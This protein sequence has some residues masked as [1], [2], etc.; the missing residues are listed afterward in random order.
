M[1]NHVFPIND[2]IEHNTEGFECS[3]NPVIDFENEIVIH[4]SLDR[5]ECFEEK[6]SPSMASNSSAPENTSE[7]RLTDS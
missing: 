3:C 4:N 6:K 7:A 2:L 1:W 5:R